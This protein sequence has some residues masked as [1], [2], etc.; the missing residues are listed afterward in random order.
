IAGAVLLGGVLEAVIGFTGLMGLIRRVLSPVVIGP[1]IM[2]IG[3]AL[4][5][6]GAPVAAE[7][8]GVSLL[9]MVL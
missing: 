2:L 1:V 9:T 8:W 3:L 4:Y 6:F 5:Q 7:H